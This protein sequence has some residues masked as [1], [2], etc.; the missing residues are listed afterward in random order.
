MQSS[1]TGTA[2][3]R[4]IRAI[5]ALSTAL[6][7]G[8]IAIPARANVLVSFPDFTAACGSPDLTCIGNAATVGPV[9]RLTQ[10]VGGES[11]AAYSTNPVTLGANATF[12]TAFQF[13]FSNPGGIDPADGMTF[14]LAAKPT[15]LGGSGG[16]MGYQGVPKSVAVEFDTYLNTGIDL[17]SNHVAVDEGGQL[18]GL[19]S[20]NPYGNGSCGFANGLPI[21]NP[22]TALGCMANG[23]V[24]SVRISY[25]GSLLDVTVQDG[26][27]P[28]QDIIKDFPINIA[29]QLGTNTAFVG[30]TAGT[31][32]GFENH[33]I[34]NWR[35]ANTVELAQ[36]PEPASLALVGLGLAG[37]G[38]GRRKGA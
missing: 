29:A 12:S 8:L 26:A 13:R 38:L 20:A 27:N 16:A 37:I 19:A 24:W 14:V 7:T 34:L 25:D 33:D 32:G 36:A 35:F 30:F 17:S 10:A 2:P 6:L 28:E 9:L 3:I 5:L 15:G 22:N 31:A 18:T 1:R 23:D 11:G 4:A 21:Q